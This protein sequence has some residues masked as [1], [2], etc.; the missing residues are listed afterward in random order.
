MATLPLFTD[1]AA[2]AA[3]VPD[4]ATVVLATS[5]VFLEPDVILE[6]LEQRFL[7][8]GHPRDLTVVHP[9][10]IGDQEG[11]ALRRL[12]HPRMVRKVVGGHWSW[13]PAVRRLAHG[14]RIE[15]YSL[16]AGVIRALLGA[17]AAGG[18]GLVTKIGLGT[19][20]D[21]RHGGGRIN[22][23][24]RDV[25]TEV[26]RVDG[27]EWLR[28]RPFRVDVAIIRATSADRCGTL[29]SSHAPWDPGI[30]GAALAARGTGGQVLAQVAHVED[31]RAGQ[32]SPAAGVRADAIVEV[33]ET[34][35]AR[36]ADAAARTPRPV[37]RRRFG[38]AFGF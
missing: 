31:A 35:G 10:G 25:L 11:S 34:P 37:P 9:L 21:P 18:Q 29:S 7:A 32:V 2:L 23:A 30:R 26:V 22:A 15:A 27:S 12:A 17:I 1:A 19:L 36:V 24:A 5:G 16:P 33:P 28:Y 4:G 20:P 8:T 14:N 3:R 38:P 6:A 13:S